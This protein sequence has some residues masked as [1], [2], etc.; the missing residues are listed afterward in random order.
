MEAQLVN[1]IHRIGQTRKVRVT[2]LVMQGTAEER[3]MEMWAEEGKGEG[4]GDAD[5]LAEGSF[6]PAASGRDDYVTK[7]ARA[8]GIEFEA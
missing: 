2:R 8:I 5:D 6:D 1:R 3:T 4:G 7:V